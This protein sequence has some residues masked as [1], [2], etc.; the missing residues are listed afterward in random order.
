VRGLAAK[1]SDEFVDD[2]CIVSIPSKGWG[3]AAAAKAALDAANVNFKAD[4]FS[5]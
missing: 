1:M 2:Y 5:R 4:V 3:L